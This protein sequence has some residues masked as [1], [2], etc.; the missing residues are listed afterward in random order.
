VIKDKHLTIINQIDQ[1]G[2]TSVL[3]SPNNGIGTLYMYIVPERGVIKVSNM[4]RACKG[5]WD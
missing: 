4:N 3:K 5:T 2:L 1:R